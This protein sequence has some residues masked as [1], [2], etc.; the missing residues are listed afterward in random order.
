VISHF[1]LI[2]LVENFDALLI[3]SEIRVL[4]W[5]ITRWLIVLCVIRA[6]LHCVNFPAAHDVFGLLVV[7]GIFILAWKKLGWRKQLR[8]FLLGVLLFWLA[9]WIDWLDGLLGQQGFWGELADSADDLLLAVGFFFIALAFIRL[10][11]ERDR[12]ETKLR[13]MAYEDELTGLGNRRSLFDHL[14]P[15]LKKSSGTLLYID[16]DH[17]KSVNDQYGHDIGD[18]VLQECGRIFS[19]DGREQTYRMGGDEFVLLL[20]SSEQDFVTAQIAR[21]HEGA[22][23][24]SEKYGIALSIGSIIFSPA[25]LPDVDTALQLADQQMYAAKRQSRQSVRK[26]GK[27]SNADE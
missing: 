27:P 7:S 13:Q 19:L 10:M 14:D 8:P 15:L 9:S 20:D 24:L 16:V 2:S 22:R 26:T 4:N 25:S 23:G 12:L 6:S 18:F 17:F 21:L 3:A 5:S 1:R 11:L